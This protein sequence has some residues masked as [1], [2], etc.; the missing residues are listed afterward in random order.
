[1]FRRRILFSATGALGAIIATATIALAVWSASG[2]GTGDA[3]AVVA[4]PVTITTVALSSTAASLYP[5]GPAGNVYMNINNPN[6]YP[7]TITGASWGLVTST[8]TT[9]CANSNISVDPAAPTGPFSIP[10]PANGTTVEEIPA[11]LDLSH[12]APDGCQ[13]VGFNVNVTLTGTQA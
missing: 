1:M 3:L 7:I 10:V 11:V 2:S 9:T 8:N 6:P 5:G 13:G 4:K 12:A